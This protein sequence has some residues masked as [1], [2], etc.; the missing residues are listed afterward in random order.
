MTAN[1]TL[2]K[3][4]LDSLKDFVLDMKDPRTTLSQPQSTR[5]HATLRRELQDVVVT[6]ADGKQSY[7]PVLHLPFAARAEVGVVGGFL[8]TRQE[9]AIIGGH[10]R[11]REAV[12]FRCVHESVPL[13]AIA[14]G[15]IAASFSRD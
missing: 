11:S 1:E 14:D 7:R 5:A 9:L 4:S 2:A 12:V 15:Y 10:R 6:S 13:Y 3:D 8:H